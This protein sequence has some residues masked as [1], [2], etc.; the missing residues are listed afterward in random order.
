MAMGAKIVFLSLLVGAA[1]AAP[2][3]IDIAGSGLSFNE[4]DVHGETYLVATMGV[5]FDQD[6]Y[7]ENNSG[8]KKLFNNVKGG[9]PGDIIRSTIQRAAFGTVKMTCGGSGSIEA[10]GFKMKDN[11]LN[12]WHNGQGFGGG[13]KYFLYFLVRR[14]YCRI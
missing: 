1:V 4:I 8:E 2:P 10:F 12:T 13:G 9:N 7:V 11:K 5:A 6:I 3:S 14:M